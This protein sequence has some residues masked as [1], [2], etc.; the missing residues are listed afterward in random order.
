[1]KT[2]LDEIFEQPDV[3]R[4]CLDYYRSEA[5]RL[6]GCLGRK[7]PA[8]ITFTGMGASLYA[9]LPAVYYLNARGFSTRLSLI[10][11]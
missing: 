2:F 3:L 10:H 8:T 11:I 9:S 5:R 1:M 7:P 6:R 4:H